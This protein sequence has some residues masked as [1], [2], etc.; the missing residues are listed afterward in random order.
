MK[1]TV[2]QRSM[3]AVR[4]STKNDVAKKVAGT[5]VTIG[6]FFDEAAKEKLK[7]KPNAKSKG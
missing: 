4:T 6:E 5:P 7:T 1:K 3:V 2:T